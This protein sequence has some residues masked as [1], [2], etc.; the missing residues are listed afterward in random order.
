MSRS[1]K[2]RLK[3]RYLDRR[4]YL[5]QGLVNFAS[6]SG[7][8]CAGQLFSGFGFM[9]GLL[10]DL[11]SGSRAL[12]Q[13]ASS[14][15]HKFVM[16]LLDGG[17][18]SHFATDPILEDRAASEAFESYLASMQVRFPTG[19]TQ[20][21]TGEGFSPALNAFE[22][23]PTAFVNGMYVDVPAHNSAQAFLLTGKNLIGRVVKEPAL[24]AILASPIG[25]FASH[26]V[27]GGN[28]PLGPTL[29]T[30]P[31]LVSESG[32]LDKILSSATAEFG[33]SVQGTLNKTLRLLNDSYFEKL[34][35]QSKNSVTPFYELAG[36]MTGIFEQFGGRFEIS[37]EQKER[38]GVSDNWDL[39]RFIGASQTLQNSLSRIVTLRLGGFDTH[40]NEIANQLPRQQ[41]VSSALNLFVEDLKNSEDPDSPGVSLAENT[42]I[43][44]ASEFVRTPHFN[45]SAG[46]DHQSSASCILMGK[47]V[48]D[49]TV[50]G[51]TDQE[52]EA[53]G[54]HN[55]GA[56][57]R[58]E[59]NQLDA[60]QL[61]ATV[62]K[63]FGLQEE[64][65]SIHR[66]Q[67]DEL[68]G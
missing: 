29:E 15:P 14:N 35:T 28:V 27:L 52:G 26:V 65:D 44:I 57:A 24:P 68:V 61:V 20:L 5:K 41:A 60:A 64:A 40:S 11:L 47:G 39:I 16:V 9:P 43:L 12:A 45:G 13:E 55:G 22:K 18:N 37:D 48:R 31:P 30:N 19:K 23:M 3:Q 10:P 59:E 67:M 62:L 2:K 7:L 36:K 66:K 32:R 8:E 46:T 1:D 6:L 33:D 21:A 50:L 34:P 17:W 42:T 56:E 49:N 53:M 54:W 51:K 58:T 38:Y 25:G 4:Q 63:I